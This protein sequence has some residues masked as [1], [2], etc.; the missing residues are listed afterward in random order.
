L[1]LIGNAFQLFVGNRFAW[2]EQNSEIGD[3]ASNTPNDPAMVRV[4]AWVFLGKTVAVD[5]ECYLNPFFGN[6]VE[7]ES[8]VFVSF[9]QH[10][11]SGGFQKCPTSGIL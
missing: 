3:V 9:N 5:V 11:I 8:A 1:L 4:E 7:R 2:F 6:T 10:V